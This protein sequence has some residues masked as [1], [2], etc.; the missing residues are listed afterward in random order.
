MTKTNQTSIRSKVG[1]KMALQACLI[2][3]VAILSIAFTSVILEQFLVR[4]ALKREANHFWENYQSDSTFPVPNTDNLK[5]YLTL[6]GSE[7][8]VPKELIGYELGFHK[9]DGQVGLSLIHI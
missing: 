5:G 8:G 9:I 2:A 7:E 3:I 6:A 1:R 4:E